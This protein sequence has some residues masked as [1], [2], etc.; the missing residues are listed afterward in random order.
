MTWCR[1]IINHEIQA[2]VYTLYQERTLPLPDQNL[3][4]TMLA[5]LNDNDSL[6]L[7][8]NRHFNLFI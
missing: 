3:S 6:M 5:P 7:G 1:Y 2:H 8:I 4:E